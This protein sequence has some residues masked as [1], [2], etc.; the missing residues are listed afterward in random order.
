MQL[1]PIAAHTFAVLLYSSDDAAGGLAACGCMGFFGFLIIAI[2]AL[3][4]ALLVWVARDAKNRNMDTPVLWMILVVLTGFIG[5]IIYILVR[6]Q[7]NLVR[8]T[9]CN[10]KRM[11]VSAKC[12]HCGNP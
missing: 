11:Q 8:C 9:H 6:P 7:G 10:N 4:I 5:L 3:N 1:V 12:P 2:I